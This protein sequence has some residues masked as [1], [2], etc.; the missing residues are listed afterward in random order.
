MQ[1]ASKSLHVPFVL[2]LTFLAG[3]VLVAN[4]EDLSD[5]DALES[6]PFQ[7]NEDCVDD[8]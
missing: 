6:D 2:K 5:K 3:F 8:I 1:H 7:Y 4:R